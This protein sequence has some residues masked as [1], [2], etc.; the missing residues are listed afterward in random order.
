MENRVSCKKPDCYKPE[1][2]NPYPLCVGN[3]NKECENCCLY[4]HMKGEG[5]YED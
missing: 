1:E 4:V 2:N 3:G 5:G